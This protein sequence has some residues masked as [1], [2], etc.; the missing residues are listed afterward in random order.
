[1]PWQGGVDALLLWLNHRREKATSATRRQRNGVTRWQVGLTRSDFGSLV[2]GERERKMAAGELWIR[3][4]TSPGGVGLTPCQ[5]RGR[6]ARFTAASGSQVSAL[7]TQRMHNS[8]AQAASAAN[9]SRS[10]HPLAPA[11]HTCRYP[12]V[13]RHTAI[14]YTQQTLTQF[15]INPGPAS[16]TLVQHW[17]IIGSMFDGIAIAPGASTFILTSAKLRHMSHAPR[18]LYFKSYI[19]RFCSPCVRKKT[20]NQNTFPNNTWSN[21]R[22]ICDVY[23]CEMH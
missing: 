5:R 7:S 17:T 12:G 15:W 1:M 11:G 16:A 13:M 3:E 22:F 4:N 21:K 6:R 2:F 9:Y 18:R 10:R 20:T 14:M 23:R 19:Q 8:A